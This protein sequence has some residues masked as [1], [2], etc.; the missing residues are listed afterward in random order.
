MLLLLI[1]A[2]RELQWRGLS[3]G[4]M[5]HKKPRVVSSQLF[6]KSS[7]FMLVYYEENGY[8]NSVIQY[9][10]WWEIMC[11]CVWILILIY[12][13]YIYL[14]VMSSRICLGNRSSSCVTLRWL[15]VLSK[16]SICWVQLKNCR[17]SISPSIAGEFTWRFH[18]IFPIIFMWIILH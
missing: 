10:S 4:L 14:R 13:S 5:Y 8:Q 1:L 17:I 18:C 16:L 15:H 2:L 11:F 7:N 3:G 9:F 12:N 6:P